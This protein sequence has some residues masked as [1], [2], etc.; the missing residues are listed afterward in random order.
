MQRP[1]WP[2][3]PETPTPPPPIHNGHHKLVSPAPTIH[4]SVCDVC[5]FYLSTGSVQL[6]PSWG[7]PGGCYACTHTRSQILGATPVAPHLLSFGSIV[8]LLSLIWSTC[9]SVSKDSEPSEEWMCSP[10][11]ARSPHQAW[12][13]AQWVSPIEESLCFIHSLNKYS[14]MLV[15]WVDTLWKILK[16]EEGAWEQWGQT[17]KIWR[18]TPRR[19]GCFLV[20][21]TEER[22]NLEA[23]SQSWRIWNED[24]KKQ[25]D[26]EKNRT[27]FVTAGG[28]VT[29]SAMIP[30]EETRL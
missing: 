24:C 27:T 13:L 20:V 7:F 5:A 26:H 11:P 2:D 19:N 17:A 6:A 10:D 22:K 23:G 30:R 25:E 4:T 21:Q 14:L 15:E 12:C 9:L 29:S 1:S 3:P 8:T 18:L 28:L 16:K